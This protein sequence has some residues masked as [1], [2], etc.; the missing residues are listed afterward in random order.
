MSYHFR[1]LSGGKGDQLREIEAAIK[2]LQEQ[3][4]AL[5]RPSRETLSERNLAITRRLESGEAVASICA[6]F[7]LRRARV[8]EIAAKVKLK[9]RR[10]LQHSPAPAAAALVP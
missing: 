1:F 6:E 7:R 8:H 9:A 2:K 4:I 3:R 10:S 5:I